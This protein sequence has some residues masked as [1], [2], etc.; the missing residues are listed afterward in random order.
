MKGPGYHRSSAADV[1]VLALLALTALLALAACGGPT[2]NAMVLPTPSATGTIAIETAPGGK[3]GIYLVNADRSGLRRVVENPGLTEDPAWSPDGSQI[4]Y[5][6]YPKG[7]GDSRRASLWLANADGSGQRQVTSG[8]VN[9]FMPSWSP[10]GTQI[11][12]AQTLPPEVANTA[13]INADGSGL[14]RLTD[15]SGSD[16]GSV[17]TRDGRILFA[18]GGSLFAINPD[19]SG[20]TELTAFG[21]VENCLIALSPDGTKLALQTLGTPSHIAVFP[22]PDG[23][24]PVKLLDPLSDYLM[25]NRR[26]AMSWTPDGKALVVAA[27]DELEPDGSRLFVI[28]ADG[29]GLS[30]VPGIKFAWNPA[31]RP[32]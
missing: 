4:V 1:L 17:W 21:H 12:F 16:F 31:W 25:N 27:S 15:T 24:T 30:A 22:F 23:G 3:K 5:V 32:E 19:G 13:V 18:H 11:A 6:V 7:T 26:A 2:E 9:G 10:D 14:K 20:R 8:D 28:N 29:S